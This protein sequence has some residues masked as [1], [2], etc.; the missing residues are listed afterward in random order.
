M[1]SLPLP[2][3]QVRRSLAHS[4]AAPRPVGR[5]PRCAAAGLAAT[6]WPAPR[7][8]SDVLEASLV[9]GAGSAARRGQGAAK[10]S[11]KGAA[12][13]AAP[14]LGGRVARQRR[15]LWVGALKRRRVPREPG[16]AAGQAPA[17][18]GPLWADRAARAPTVA[19]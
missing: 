3:A 4:P 12:K 13:G 5:D 2:R 18:S 6:D 19:P 1:P 10:G 11:A 14:L 9:I 8:Q 7:A 16:A 15:P 17:P